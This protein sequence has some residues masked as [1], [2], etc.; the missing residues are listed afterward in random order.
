MWGEQH[1]TFK[2]H[3]CDV[4]AAGDS[5]QWSASIL[6]VVLAESKMGTRGLFH[7]WFIFNGRGSWDGTSYM[8]FTVKW[9]CWVWILM[10]LHVNMCIK[11]SGMKKHRGPRDW[12]LETQYN[13]EQYCIK[14]TV[15]SFFIKFVSC[16]GHQLNFF[17]FCFFCSFLPWIIRAFAGLFPWRERSD[18]RAMVQ[19]S[20]HLE[21]YKKKGKHKN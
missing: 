10:W 8:A 13:G 20:F 12:R 11:Y 9:L 6:Q 15:S 3:H 4:Q 2:T 14:H 16:Q 19:L 18:L 17:F 21:K 5:G 1:R 7:Y